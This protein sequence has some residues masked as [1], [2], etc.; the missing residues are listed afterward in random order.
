MCVSPSRLLV[1]YAR[2]A[3]AKRGCVNL[4][5]ALRLC[6]Q[7]NMSYTHERISPSHCDYFCNLLLR[8]SIRCEVWAV[9]GREKKHAARHASHFSQNRQLAILKTRLDALCLLC[10]KPLSFR[11]SA[12]EARLQ[13]RTRRGKREKGSERG[14]LS[15]GRGGGDEQFPPR[16]RRPE[17]RPP[18][19]GPRWPAALRRGRRVLRRGLCLF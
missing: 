16:G 14:A 19:H 12:V 10:S 11:G 5:I 9:G 8:Q 6:D 2:K 4:T 15:T 7:Q 3:N 13:K 1:T 17:P 18:P